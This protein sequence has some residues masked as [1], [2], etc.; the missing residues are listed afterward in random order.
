MGLSDGGA[1][2][3]GEG[4]DNGRDSELH[5]EVERRRAEDAAGRAR[6]EMSS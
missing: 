3:D 1:D 5:D 6:D 4:D 2:E